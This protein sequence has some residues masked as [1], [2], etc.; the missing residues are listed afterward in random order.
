MVILIVLCASWG[1]QQ[2]SIKVA[3]AG[4]SPVLQAGIRSIGAGALLWLWM[5]LRGQPV[6]ERD[7]TLWWGLAVGLGF[8]AEFVL[9]YW[10]LEYTHASRAVVFLYTMPFVTAL[11]AQLFLP[12]ERLR[13]AQ[14]AG[15]CLAFAGI[16]VAFGESIALPTRTTLIGDGMALGAAVLWGGCTVAIKATRL[17]RIRPAKTLLYQLAVSALV[18]PLFSLVLGETGIRGMTPLIAACLVYQ[19][20]C[21]AFVTYLVWFWLIRNYPASR[22]AGFLFFTPL[23]G[24]LFGAALLGE[25]LTLSLL[26]AL[27]LVGA[28]IYLVNR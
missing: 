28:G 24:V 22:L 9:V 3:N 8:A 14:V 20:V 26:T 11:G 7:G 4:V 15:L 6:L 17:S 1:L 10:G 12:A 16:V 5:R 21:V 2:V 19:A 25:P 13:A 27:A 18:L 23:F